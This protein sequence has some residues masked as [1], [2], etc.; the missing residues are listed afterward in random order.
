M[1]A[2]FHTAP[3]NFFYPNLKAVLKREK[4]PFGDA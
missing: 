1:T 2:L 3:A 4:I